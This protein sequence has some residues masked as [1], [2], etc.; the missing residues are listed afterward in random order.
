MSEGIQCTQLKENVKTQQADSAFPAGQK[1]FPVPKAE[2]ALGP[3]QKP[4]RLFL[5]TRFFNFSLS[6]P[7]NLLL[8]LVFCPTTISS[9]W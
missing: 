6:Y 3:I 5:M 9:T 8:D 1:L 2:S 7:L 4:S